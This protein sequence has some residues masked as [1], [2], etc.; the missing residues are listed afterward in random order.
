VASDPSYNNVSLLVLANGADASTAFVDN[1]PTPKT[2]TAFGNAHI[3]TAQAKFSAS[4]ALFDGTGDYLSVPA[5][6][7]FN[8]GSG[9]FTLEAHIYLTGYPNLNGGNYKSAII[10]KDVS[11]GRQFSLLAVGTVSSYTGLEFVGFSAPAVGTTVSATHAFALNTWYHVELVRSGN[12][13][14]VFVDGVLKNVGGTAFSENIQNTS[15]ALLVGANN[16]DATYL[17]EFKGYIDNLR[18]TKGVARHTATFTPP[19]EEPAIS[20]G[21]AALT[22]PMCTVSASASATVLHASADLTAPSPLVVATCGGFSQIV[23]PMGTLTGYFGGQAALTAPSPRL[24]ATMHNATGE[25]ALHA[26]A[27]MGTLEAFTGARIGAAA[28]MGTLQASGTVTQ[29]ASAALTA[30]MQT[31]QATGTVSS[32]AQLAITAPMQQAVG[33]GGAVISAT[34][35]MATVQASG[36]T[37]AVGAIA[38]TCPLF[39]LVATASAQAHARADLIAPMPTM[40]QASLQA[41]VVAPMGQLVAIGTA[42]VTAT[43]EAYALNLKH[44]P[45]YEGPHELTRYTNF[46]FDCIVRYRNSYLGVHSSGLYLLKGT[47]DFADPAPTPIEWDWR[48]CL[49]DFGTPNKKTPV[50]AYIG[51]RLGPEATITLVEGETADRA[52]SFQ[53]PRG[54]AAQNYRQ[55]FGRGVKARYFAL[56]VAGNGELSIDTLDFNIATL[57]RRI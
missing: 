37:G 20:Y 3:S 2:I 30:P 1:A 25:N 21:S 4:S 13:V 43:Y 6:T 18:I 41:W 12:L 55:K 16:F 57:A 42:V 38:V 11:T 5:H 10:A 23:A 8:F 47:T 17:Y 32:M 29:I 14:Y 35:G 15:T 19:T 39:E 45:G 31:L 48:T 24:T 27:P 7:D 22:A 34:V 46:P 36:T 51:G 50:S 26:T 44:A 56:G 52:H 33:Y 40:G 28:P 9:A 54:S 49:T 53:T